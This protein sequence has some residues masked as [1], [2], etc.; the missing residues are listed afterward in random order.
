MLLVSTGKSI[1]LHT[2][3][4]I[5][6]L[7]FEILHRPQTHV[8]PGADSIHNDCAPTDPLKVCMAPIS[9]LCLLTG[10]TAVFSSPLGTHTQT[11]TR[12]GAG[13]CRVSGRTRG[14]RRLE[15]RRC[16]CTHQLEILNATNEVGGVGPP[17]LDVHT[18]CTQENKRKDF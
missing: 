9:G 12:S 7:P 8:F 11:H 14:R 2:T 10:T 17:T 13:E 6:H 1:F 16:K 15:D 18:I 5:I 3:S 4:F